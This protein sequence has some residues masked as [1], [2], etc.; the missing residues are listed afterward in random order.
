MDTGGVPALVKILAS[1]A[2]L[3]KE[4]ATRVMENL[5]VTER[6]AGT[7]VSAGVELPL[8]S[9]LEVV[10]EGVANSLILMKL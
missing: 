2:P 6:H 3:L 8:K 9:L 5:A 4:K 7:I 1:E 10:S